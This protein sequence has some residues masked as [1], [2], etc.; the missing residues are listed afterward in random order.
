MDF[1]NIH[2]LEN[3]DEI[4]LYPSDHFAYRITLEWPYT[5]DL[6]DGIEGNEPI[7]HYPKAIKR[8]PAPAPEP[9]PAPAPAPAPVN[10]PPTQNNQPVFRDPNDSYGDYGDYSD[11][12]A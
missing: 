2:V 12:G 3:G 8:P 1:K 4:E 10:H 11:N 5:G 9:T 7:I 6:F